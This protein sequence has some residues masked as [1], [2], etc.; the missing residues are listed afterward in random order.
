MQAADSA[1]SR[2]HV[3]G[4]QSR[5]DP[6]RR[7]PAGPGGAHAVRHACRLPG[8]RRLA[9]PAGAAGTVLTSQGGTVLAE[10]RP[11][12]AYLVSWSPTQGYE[13]DDVARGPGRHGAGGLRIRR[14][15]GDDGG[16]LPGR[17]GRATC[18]LLVHPT[19]GAS[20]TDE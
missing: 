2:P 7:D 15:L 14:E 13:A 19:P 9:E 17:H 16:V 20:G 6:A 11:A 10:C 5:R 1:P 12:G 4:E 8:G 18:R 3:T